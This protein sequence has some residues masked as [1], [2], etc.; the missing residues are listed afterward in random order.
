MSVSAAFCL[1]LDTIKVVPCSNSRHSE[2]SSIER[3]ILA[4]AIASTTTKGTQYEPYP[5]DGLL[6]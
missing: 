1:V 3:S 5:L 4:Y 2:V 6:Y